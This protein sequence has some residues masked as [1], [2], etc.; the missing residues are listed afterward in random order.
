MVAL[1]AVVV[2]RPQ[3]RHSS[4]PEL[5]AER[6]RC[7]IPMQSRPTYTPA[8]APQRKQRSII[9]VSDSSPW[10][11][12]FP[13]RLPA[14]PPPS[15]RPRCR[16]R[17]RLRARRQRAPDALDDLA[18]AP[19]ERARAGEHK[20]RRDDRGEAYPDGLGGFFAGAVFGRWG[21]VVVVSAVS[22]RIVLVIR[23]RRRRWSRRRSWQ[24]KRG[25]GSGGH[26][27]TCVLDVG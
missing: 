13:R 5:S 15:T 8:S 7:R 25:R 22:I 1:C 26:R 21:A 24:S 14:S 17:C 20:G 10:A 4:A 3:R 6:P 12:L 16:A 19:D 18:R 27:A 23:R 9:S 2:E 11:H